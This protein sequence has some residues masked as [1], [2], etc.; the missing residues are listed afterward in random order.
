[1]GKNMIS[2]EVVKGKKIEQYAKYIASL[3]LLMFKEFPYLYIG[4]LEHEKKYL[5]FYSNSTDGVLILA[6]QDGCIVGLLTGMSM[7]GICEHIS[8]FKKIL[9]KNKRSIQ[10]AY[11]Y[12]EALVLEAY[13]GQGILTKMF[14]ELD[15]E[16]KHMGYNQ[17]YGI[18][19]IREKND[20]RR[21][22]NYRDTESLWEHL[23]LVKT[24]MVYGG[25]WETVSK[26]GETETAMNQLQVWE[27]TF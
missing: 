11:Y 10:S 9:D 8:D 5:A 15:A 1:M 16:I 4:S 27:K 17:A 21:P 22:S 14:Q 2:F 12:G 25:E 19:V 13:R 18:T 24:N 6:K 26:T 7:T 3:R 23:G 20:S